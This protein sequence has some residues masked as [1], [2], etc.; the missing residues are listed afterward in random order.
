ML[1][2]CYPNAKPALQ[3]P[4]GPWLALACTTSTHR[5]IQTMYQAC[6]HH[7]NA[8][9]MHPARVWLYLQLLLIEV[10]TEFISLSHSHSHVCC[11]HYI[12]PCPNHGSTWPMYYGYISLPQDPSTT[13][14]L[15]ALRMHTHGHA[16]TKR[17]TA[18]RVCSFSHTHALTP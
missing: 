11:T 6:C 2:W 10:V 16:Y 3:V 5:T 4:M 15:Y 12:C 7:D 13:R 18:R 8:S 1:H 17:N 14:S 9:G